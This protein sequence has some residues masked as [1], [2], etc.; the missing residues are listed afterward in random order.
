VTNPSTSVFE[1]GQTRNTEATIIAP[2]IAVIRA[3]SS[4][5][6]VAVGTD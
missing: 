4:Q 5:V 2:E 6:T 3:T 1:I